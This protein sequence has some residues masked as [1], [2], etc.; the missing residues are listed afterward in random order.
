M[1]ANEN[2]LCM[3][4]RMRSVCLRQT[5]L[6]F[7][8]AS[9]PR[10]PCAHKWAE[11]GILRSLP[12]VEGC[13]AAFFSL[14]H[15]TVMTNITREAFKLKERTVRKSKVIINGFERTIELFSTNH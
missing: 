9:E 6:A 8:L 13:H 1:I 7:D 4:L 14:I 5:C 2:E 15:C 12:T 10:S 11:I 3:R